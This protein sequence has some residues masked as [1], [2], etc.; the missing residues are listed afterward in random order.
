MTK[1]KNTL[2]SAHPSNPVIH[3][4]QVQSDTSTYI[5]CIS[6]SLRHLHHSPNKSMTPIT[7]N[8]R[9]LFYSKNRAMHIQ[10]KPFHTNQ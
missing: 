3:Q 5:P 10:N 9:T 7:T 4:S 1:T 6:P 2:N 8:A